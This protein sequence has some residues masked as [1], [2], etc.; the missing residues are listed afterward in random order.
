MKHALLSLSFLLL[1]IT[2]SFA[3][4]KYPKNPKVDILNYVF[5]IEL[6][7]DTDEIK[8]E[9]TIDV[10][11]KGGVDVLR[12][13]LTKSSEAL[14]NK[15]MTVSKVLAAGGKE[16][17]YSHVGEELKI[18]L[19]E[20]SYLNQR[21][22]YTVFYSG[23]PAT[24]LKI[25]NN[26]YGDRTFFSDNWPDK[27]RNWLAV[28]DHPYDK[29]TSE[30]VV[31]APDHY[32]VVSNGLMV[33]ETDLGDGNRVT[34]W[35][36]SVPIA[37]WLYVMGVA[38]FAVQ[39]VDDFDGKAIQTWVYRQDKEAGFYDFAEPTK[40]ALEF[41]SDYIG[42]F[43]YEKLA[44]IQSNSVSGGMEAASAILYSESSVVGD[45]NE[46]WRNVVIHE[47]AHQWFGNAVTEYDWDDVWLSEGFATYFT[48]LFIEHQYGHDAFMEQMASSKKRV[49]NFNAQNPGYTIVHNNL[50]DMSKVTTGQ[51]YQ[52]GSWILHM[53]RGIMGEELFWEGI[54]AYYSKYQNLNATTA[55]FRREMEEVS[56]RDLEVFFD[57]WLYKPGAMVFEG[58][59]E[60]NK[61]RQELEISLN[62]VQKDGSLF[63][64]P[65]QV[66]IYKQGEKVRLIKT[67]E[68]KEKTNSFSFALDFEP[69][70][71]ILDP[72]SWV[73]MESTFNKK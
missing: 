21:S 48:S 28:V 72:D 39:H 52:K 66:A 71:V 22:S 53:L 18:N 40:K 43:S 61:I 73:L 37:S 57:Q 33:E 34:H 20:A 27:A 3:E 4:D 65:I 1:C 70:K 2:F 25:A 67:L 35:K 8:C 56:G 46:R 54:R 7:D 47:I 36:Q 64:M 69:E 17:S 12:L 32:Q 62:Q 24:G 30:F 63:E 51:T 49:D 38:E 59:W 10:S 19:P 60:Y 14:G 55:D 13:D 15:G 16:F 5:R 29:A 58:G 45:R 42:P 31:T 11:Y 68:I 23:I 6:S 9:V 26:K 44:N 50:E 41:Y